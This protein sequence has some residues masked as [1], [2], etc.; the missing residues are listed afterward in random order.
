MTKWNKS[1]EKL[2]NNTE[3]IKSFLEKT[4]A[5][6]VDHYGLIFYGDPVSQQFLEEISIVDHVFKKGDRLSI[7]AHNY[8]GDAKL[9]WLLAW[10]NGKPTDFECKVGDIIKVPSPVEEVILQASRS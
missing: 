5:S 9:W 10:F 6:K 7:I 2:A 1:G 3:V 4:G 8:Y